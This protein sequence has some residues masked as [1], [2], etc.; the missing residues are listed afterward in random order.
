MTVSKHRRLWTPAVAVAA[1]TAIAIAVGIHQSWWSALASEL[2]ALAWAVSLYVIGGRDTDIGAAVGAKGDERQELVKLRAARLCL[3]VV[4]AAIVVGCL[5]AA[6]TKPAIWPFQIFAVV[7][8]I[9]YFYGLWFYGTGREEA[10]AA[11][12]EGENE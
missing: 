1:G 5:I 10:D 7:I 4:V 9:A 3:A 6:A 11:A 2:V 12:G 8:G